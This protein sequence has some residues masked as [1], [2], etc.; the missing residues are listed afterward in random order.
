MWSTSDAMRVLHRGRW[1]CACVLFSS[2]LCVHGPHG[3]Q[4]GTQRTAHRRPATTAVPRVRAVGAGSWV[5]ASARVCYEVGIDAKTKKTER[6]YNKIR[7]TSSSSRETRPAASCGPRWRRD[8]RLPGRAAPP[9]FT[10]RC[11][12]DGRHTSALGHTFHRRPHL[13]TAGP[14]EARGPSYHPIRDRRR[15][16]ARFDSTRHSHSRALDHTH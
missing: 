8:T 1:G 5:W 14:G 9:G 13:G 11:E 2:E 12:S 7:T 15:S 10:R 6:K 3:T 16:I 4:L